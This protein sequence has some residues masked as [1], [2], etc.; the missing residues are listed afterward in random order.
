MVEERAATLAGQQAVC[1]KISA[2]RCVC[3]VMLARTVWTTHLHCNIIYNSATYPVDD[4][5]AVGTTNLL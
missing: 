4:D 5:R 3:V 1:R 2:L